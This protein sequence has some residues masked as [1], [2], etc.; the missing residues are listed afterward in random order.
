MNRYIVIFTLIASLS[1]FLSGCGKEPQ[2]SIKPQGNAEGYSGPDTGGTSIPISVDRTLTEEELQSA[3]KI[4][5][6][7]TATTLYRTLFKRDMESG[8]SL[9]SS[10]KSDCGPTLGPDVTYVSNSKTCTVD[11]KVKIVN[12]LGCVMDMSLANNILIKLDLDNER[13]VDVSDAK[14]RKFVLTNG[15][16]FFTLRYEMTPT[17]I[18]YDAYGNV[19]NPDAPWKISKAFTNGQE[20]SDATATKLWNNATQQWSAITVNAKEYNLCLQSEAQKEVKVKVKK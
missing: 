11:P 13:C 4:C 8:S 12:S 3:A 18:Q 1:F 9:D 17:D 7:K 6:T 20:I 10:A 16:N 2:N 14:I 19:I 5:A 15:S